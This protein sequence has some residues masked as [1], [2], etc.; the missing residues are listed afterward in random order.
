MPISPPTAP[1]PG[2]T[3]PGL[4]S[5]DASPPIRPGTFEFNGAAL[6][7]EDEEPPLPGTHP[8]AALLNM[9]ALQLISLSKVVP[10]VL[11]SILGGATPSIVMF[12]AAPSSPVPSTFTVA[13]GS[14]GVTTIVY[15]NATFPAP[16]AMPTV[17]LNGAIGA[18]TYASSVDLSVGATNT[19]ITVYTN[20]DGAL[21]YIPFTVAIH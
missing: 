11:L 13:S 10:N 3:C 6:G 12:S 19:T 8:T 7:N 14:T 2:E 15:P 21:A 18:H 1:L 17:S 5:W 16:V 9:T 4:S 20:I